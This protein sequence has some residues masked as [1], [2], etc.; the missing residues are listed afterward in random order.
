MLNTYK[1]IRRL[2]D[3]IGDGARVSFSAD[4]HALCVR[5]NWPNDLHFTY[6]FSSR[7]IEQIEYDEFFIEQVVHKAKA[8]MNQRRRA[9]LGDADSE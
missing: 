3:A 1:L 9:T 6:K 2:E 8:G 5:V 7:D 4:Y